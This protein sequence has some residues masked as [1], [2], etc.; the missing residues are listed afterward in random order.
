MSNEIYRDQIL[1]NYIDVI[2][3]PSLRM[4]LSCC[5]LGSVGCWVP[6]VLGL[7]EKAPSAEN[8]RIC[9]EAKW[10]MSILLRIRVDLEEQYGLYCG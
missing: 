9:Y 6:Y 1:V 8:P 4:S 2:V 7:D 3:L 10:S 5:D